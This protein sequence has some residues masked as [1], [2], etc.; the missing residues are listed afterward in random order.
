MS[1]DLTGALMQQ[2]IVF[3]LVLTRLSALIMTAP[4]YGATY[5]PM[6]VRA[7]LAI[8]LSLLITPLFWATP[9]EAPANLLQLAAMV[10]REA[11]L[12]LMLGVSVLILVSGLQLAGQLISQVGG[13]QLADVFDPTFDTSLPIFSKLLELVAVAV[14]L[15]IGGHRQV[16]EALL[17]SF[18]SI[19]P[20]CVTWSE[21]WTEALCQI[22]MQSFEV[23]LRASAP[24]VIALLMSTLILGLISRTVPQLNIL[25]VGF[26]LN[27]LVL[28]GTMSFC[29]GV[30]AW[31]LQ[32]QAALVLENLSSLLNDSSVSP[33]LGR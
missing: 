18:H 10:A 33:V 25:A 21:S 4:G 15:S 14:F 19:P 20:G 32:D 7:I 24:V 17:Y 16:M 3:V 30:A 23:G 5:T 31:I 13:L 26:G 1:G 28:L 22:A 9:L 27:S 6:Q 8:G 29:I 12:G 2:A 11:S